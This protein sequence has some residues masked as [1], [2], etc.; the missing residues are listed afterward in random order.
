MEE[1]AGERRRVEE[2][3][4]VSSSAVWARQQGTSSPHPSPPAAGR[5]GEEGHVL[6]PVVG[7]GPQVNHTSVTRF[8]SLSSIQNGGEGRGEE[9]R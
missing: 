6:E 9:A 8:F 1:R 4:S 7:V 3:K 2:K 5:E